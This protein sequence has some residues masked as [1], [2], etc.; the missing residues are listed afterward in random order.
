VKKLYQIQGRLDD[1]EFKNE[2][3][4]LMMVQH[5]NIIQLVGYCYEIRHQLVEI[6]GRNILAE[7]KERALCFEYLPHGSLDKHLSGM[8]LLN[9]EC[10]IF[11]VLNAT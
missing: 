1:V 9:L 6:E 5:N 10:V 11:H 3:N 2:F 7:R 4:N 8:T